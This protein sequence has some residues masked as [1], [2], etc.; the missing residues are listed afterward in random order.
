M[1]NNKASVHYKRKGEHIGR[2]A[3][4]NHPKQGGRGR[5]KKSGLTQEKSLE[6]T[7]GETQWG[8]RLDVA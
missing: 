7:G 3:S 8:Q 6:A 2:I 4:L 1:L 5:K